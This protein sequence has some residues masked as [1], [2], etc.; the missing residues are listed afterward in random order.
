M[1]G[2]DTEV[3][4]REDVDVPHVKE[5]LEELIERARRGDDVC[6]SDAK[7]GTVRLVRAE[8]PSVARSK[9]V[10]GQ[11]KL[12]PAITQVRL[13]AP[14]ANDELQWPSGERSPVE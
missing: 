4:A 12:L 9:I 1:A 7:G 14:L 10:F 5:H 3:R 8:A 2:F 11:W 13:L 6:I